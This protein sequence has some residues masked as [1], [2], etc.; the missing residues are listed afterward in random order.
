M[1]TTEPV[2]GN[3]LLRGI[4]AFIF[5]FLISL[6]AFLV[7]A[8]LIPFLVVLVFALG[9]RPPIA[10]SLFYY[11]VFVLLIGVLSFLSTVLLTPIFYGKL[12]GP[13]SRVPGSGS[14]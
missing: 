13:L 8:V 11:F 10:E 12:S 9:D 6:A 3:R 5:A 14:V 2:I 4:T 1:P 7:L